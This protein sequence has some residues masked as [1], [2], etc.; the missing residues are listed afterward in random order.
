MYD[1]VQGCG[2]VVALS[3]EGVPGLFHTTEK[4]PWAVYQPEPLGLRHGMHMEECN[5]EGLVPL[6]VGQQEPK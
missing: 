3:S 2:G 6:G 1:R 4:M 5:E